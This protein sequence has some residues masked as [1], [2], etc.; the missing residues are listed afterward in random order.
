MIRRHREA[1]PVPRDLGDRREILLRVVVDVLEHER[2][3]HRH[4][5]R[6]E[7]E[8]GA[9]GG[10]ALEGVDR[11]ASARA[12]PVLDHHRL[13]EALPE[14]VGDQARDDVRLPAGGDGHD[15]P[16]RLLRPALRVCGRGRSGR[17]DR[18]QQA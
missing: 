12:G 10:R 8:R 16:D 4:R 2:D 17:D 3:E 15:D 18:Q 11:D 13:P 9:V 5:D 1:E 6:R 7:E 14:G